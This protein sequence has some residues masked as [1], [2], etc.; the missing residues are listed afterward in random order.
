[1]IFSKYVDAGI[2]ERTDLLEFFFDLFDQPGDIDYF[3]WG[4]VDG[5]GLNIYLSLK[6][7]YPDFKIDLW[8]EAY[9]A[10]LTRNQWRADKSKLGESVEFIDDE[11][12]NK[13]LGLVK[14][15]KAIPQEVLHFSI[16]EELVYGQ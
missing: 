11:L 15:S 7:K 4:D 3:Y 16:L 12:F 1:M 5:A 14:D 8:E 9:V 10:M 13:L 6:K 2:V